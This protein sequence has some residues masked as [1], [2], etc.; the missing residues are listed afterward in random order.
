MTVRE[1]L[2]A[3]SIP[4]P[5]TGCVLWTRM[6]THDGYGRIKSHGRH[7]WAHR[8]AYEAYVGQ[9]PAGL[10]IDHK[11]RVRCCINPDHLEAVT[12]RENTLRGI[13][14]SAQHAKKTHCPAGHEYSG[15]NLYMHKGRRHCRACMRGRQ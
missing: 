10:T 15:T 6:T 2:E 13:G 12:K 14:P 4:E 11:C 8:E 9:I 1:R 3:Y 5:N 7:L